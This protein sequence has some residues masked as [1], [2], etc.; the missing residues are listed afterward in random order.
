MG[1]F[2]H[3]LSTGGGSG[4]S[5]ITRY[6]A[7]RDKDLGREGPGSRPL[8]S[9]DRDGLSY[10]KAD[11]LL[12]PYE[13]QPDKNDLIHLSVMVTQE[14]FE[15]LGQDEKERQERFRDMVRE[16]M[17]GLA[18]ELNVEELFWVAGI[19]RNAENP[20]AHIVMHKNAIERGTER[21]VRIHRIPKSLLP[22]RE[23]QNGKEIVVNGRI[24]DR[25]FTA[26]QN[27]Q[28]LY[29][30][31][32]EKQHELTPAEKWELLSRQHQ[33]RRNDIEHSLRSRSTQARGEGNLSLDHR[34]VSASWNFNNEVF[35][36]RY[37]DFQIALGKR[38]EFE[39]RLAFAEVWHERAVSHGDTYRF[40]VMDQSTGEERR[41]SDLDVHRRAA[42][43]ASSVDS[44]DHTKRNKAIE[45]DLTCHTETLK[46]LTEAREMKIA[47]L[48]KD[49]G[50]LR[51]NLSKVE[52]TISK[53]YEVPAEKELTPLLSREKLSELQGQAV[54]LGLVE[55]V[56]A[57]ETVRTNL[58]REHNAPTRTDSEAATLSAQ[59]HVARADFMAKEARLENFDASVHL[60][61]Y[62]IAGEHWSLAAIDKWIARRREDSKL[63]PERAARLDLRSLARI[64]YGAAGR[65]RAAAEVEHLKD[66]RREIVRQIGER[67]APLIA[68]RDQGRE[69]L[70][71]LENAY[72]REES[73][74]L[75]R[76]ETM[77]GPQYE[78]HQM[79]SLESSAEIL[80]DSNLLREVHE[81]EKDA[82]RAEN[83][84]NWEG[85]AVAREIMS[86]ITVEETKER[87][88][89][90]LESKKVASVH[91][92]NHQ[93]STLREVESR[94]LTDYLA[95][96]L[97]E[98]SA[99]R[100]H[101]YSVKSAAREH[102]GQLID[103]F[104][105]AQDYHAVAR[106]LASHIR[107]RE[108]QFTDKER[109]NLEIY[110]E[111]Q[112][113]DASRERYLELARRETQSQEHEVAAS[114]GR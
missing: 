28:T 33:A 54:R 65:E 3:I 49:V 8:F 35:D 97:L 21:P 50:S 41:I 15:K 63:I 74:R 86:G 75:A 108:P 36:N 104:Q 64:N 20:H 18:G 6:I 58:A 77:P 56:S 7:E 62:E 55:R 37:S 57:L 89:H 87:L 25:F 82:S 30:R 103:D 24:G 23:V 99:Q 111:R 67:R 19:H 66:V 107:E 13:G 100:D 10:H 16:G 112:N 109:I 88:E 113:E 73:R 76:R 26:L 46:Q 9:E 85:R 2:F 90:F 11:R 105:K 44:R 27:Q 17:K 93:T 94:T 31:S 32:L 101:R 39:M 60:T 5:R 40:E 70:D 91:I 29:S 43:R 78:R 47:T 22:H 79:N 12:D 52:Q 72:A 1:V 80:R 110:A 59:L 53:F 95:R 51:S 4:A 48:G 42:A 96:V 84:I 34:Q 45:L 98:S 69:M 102:H 81:W 71:V 61:T 14:D 106:E 114:R 68:D 83:K 92:G 38:L